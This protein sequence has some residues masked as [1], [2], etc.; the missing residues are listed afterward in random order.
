[1]EQERVSGFL[2]YT[3]YQLIQIFFTGSRLPSSLQCAEKV[4]ICFYDNLN[5]YTFLHFVATL[6]AMVVWKVITAGPQFNPLIS[7]PG[8]QQYSPLCMWLICSSRFGTVDDDDTMS[9]ISQPQV[10]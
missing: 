3:P 9:Q 1:M 4:S 6:V 2:F 10:R 8:I 7:L 5:Q